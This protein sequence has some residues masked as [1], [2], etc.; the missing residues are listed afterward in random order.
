MGIMKSFGIVKAKLELLWIEVALD[1]LVYS[2]G[3]C[4]A[5]EL[6]LEKRLG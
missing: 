6:I 1:F 5:L 4:K 3:G 2:Q